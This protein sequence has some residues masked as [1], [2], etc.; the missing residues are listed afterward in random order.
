[1][2]TAGLS[3]GNYKVFARAVES[4]GLTSDPVATTLQIQ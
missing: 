3:S 2:S 4:D 1:M